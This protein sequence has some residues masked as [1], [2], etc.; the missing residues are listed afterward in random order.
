MKRIFSLFLA[1]SI[2]VSLLLCTVGTAS[3]TELKIGIGTVEAEG[4]LYLREKPS[5]SATAVCYAEY[6]DKVVVIR[7]VDGWYLVNYNLYIGYMS[8]E[9]LS[10]SES[11]NVAL[12]KGTVDPY[13][14]NLRRSASMDSETVD[15]LDHGDTVVV[16]GLKDGWYKVRYKL[17]VAYIRSDLVTLTEKPVN[18]SGFAAPPNYYKTTSSN[19]NGNSGNSGS[20]G[21]LGSSG[22]S[23]GSGS[24]GS[25]VSTSL[26]QQIVTYAKGYLGCSYVYGGASPSG[27]DCSGFTMYVYK[28]FGYSLPHGATSQLSYGTYVS[29]DSLMPGDLVYFG[30]GSTASHVGIYI[31]GGQFIHAENYSTGVVIS[32]L[33]EN[34]YATRYLCA[35]RIV[36]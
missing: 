27:F 25:E 17:G 22:N 3:A 36:G 18:N 15:T 5:K 7:E 21:N 6:G 12:G 9:Y 10:V 24:S 4:G 31:G 11:K 2:V 30:S 32:S 8:A 1:L 19:S 23:G 16:L 14:A 34:Y 20:S 28:Q 33:S 13:Q 26:G 35:H 29:Y